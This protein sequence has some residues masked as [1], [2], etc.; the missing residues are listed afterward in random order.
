MYVG[1]EIELQGAIPSC[2]ERLHESV[3]ATFVIATDSSLEMLSV[4]FSPCLYF[5]SHLPADT[6]VEIDVTGD[7]AW[8]SVLDAVKSR[9][10]ECRHCIDIKSIKYLVISTVTTTG[11]STLTTDIDNVTSLHRAF[12]H[13]TEMN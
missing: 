5:N 10:V 3:T 13:K 7:M 6:F 11:D 8:Q 4:N 12:A 1:K 2:M 9:M